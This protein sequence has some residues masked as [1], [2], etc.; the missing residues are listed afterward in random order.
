VARPMVGVGAK[1]ARRTLIAIGTFAISLI[2]PA[3]Q[4]GTQNSASET[5]FRVRRPRPVVPAEWTPQT[6]SLRANA[7]IVERLWAREP[8]AV[9]ADYLVELR[10]FEPRCSQR[11]LPVTAAIASSEGLDG[12]TA[13]S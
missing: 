5:H 7:L 9:R 1:G 4:S 6:V 12:A 13:R 11:W 10:G 3:A 8:R 2:S